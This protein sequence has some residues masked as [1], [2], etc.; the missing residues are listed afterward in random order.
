MARD[1][2][3]RLRDAD[4]AFM[5]GGGRGGTDADHAGEGATWEEVRERGSRRV[6]SAGCRRCRA[7]PPPALSIELFSYLPSA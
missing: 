2:P 4:R 1:R 7:D 3:H 5:R 6:P